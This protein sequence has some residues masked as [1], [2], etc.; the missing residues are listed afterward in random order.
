MKNQ[1][2]MCVVETLKFLNTRTTER[3]HQFACKIKGSLRNQRGHDSMSSEQQFWCL[4]NGKSRL[5]SN[6]N[7]G[8]A[9]KVLRD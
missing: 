6:I 1:L 7:D 8:T 2:I 3:E 4:R 9:A 5:C